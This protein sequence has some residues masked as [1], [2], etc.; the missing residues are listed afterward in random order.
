MANAN[1]KHSKELR[2][3]T[4][5]EW[6]KNN[7]VKITIHLSKQYHCLVE[8]FENLPGQTKAE[9]LKILMDHYLNERHL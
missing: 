1:T 8:K 6:K 4:T 3:E 7:E 5:K 2:L 9:K